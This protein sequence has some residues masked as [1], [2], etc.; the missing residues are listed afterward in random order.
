MAAASAKPS[1]D[2]PATCGVG[3][4]CEGRGSAAMVRARAPW[5]L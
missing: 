3:R 1:V 5:P 2:D 4:A